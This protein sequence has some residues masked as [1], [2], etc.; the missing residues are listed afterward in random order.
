M[1]VSRQPVLVVLVRRDDNAA[2]CERRRK[3]ALHRPARRLAAERKD[4]MRAQILAQG[5]SE[6]LGRTSVKP[7]GS[8][9]EQ[10]LLRRMIIV[11]I[12]IPVALN[13]TL[14]LLA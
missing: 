3:R 2:T 12:G 8:S 11:V 13:L 4:T 10:Q 9:S 7:F 14:G 1:S 6:E 5:K